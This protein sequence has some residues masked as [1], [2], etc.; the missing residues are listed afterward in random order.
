MAHPAREFEQSIFSTPAHNVGTDNLLIFVDGRLKVKT[1]DYEDI[2]SD[3]VQFV[4]PILPSQVVMAFLI[5]TGADYSSSN[6]AIAQFYHGSVDPPVDMGKND[7]YYLNVISGELFNHSEGSWVSV[8]EMSATIGGKNVLTS[9]L[10]HGDVLVYSSVEDKFINQKLAAQR[11]VV[12]FIATITKIGDELSILVPHKGHAVGFQLFTPSPVTQQTVITLLK[13]GLEISEL[14]LEVGQ[15]R[16]ET[17]LP[18]TIM[19]HDIFSIRIDGAMIGLKGLNANM[20]FES[21]D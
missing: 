2:S 10:T 20:I 14:T 19:D 11:T 16:I 3:K 4:N 21:L 13:N 5:R 7:D 15:N 1:I 6:S 17:V 9:N 8:Y 12:F 18:G